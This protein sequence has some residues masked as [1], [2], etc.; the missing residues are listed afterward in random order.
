MFSKRP[1][2]ANE[3]R[4]DLKRPSRKDEDQKKV[5]SMLK[6]AETDRAPPSPEL[7]HTFRK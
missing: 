5:Q 4:E 1:P 7:R 6:S 2:N 3:L